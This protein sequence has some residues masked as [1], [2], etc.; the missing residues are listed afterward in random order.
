M[1]LNAVGLEFQLLKNFGVWERSDNSFAVI[2]EFVL[3]SVVY[4][5][6]ISK[7]AS[8]GSAHILLISLRNAIS[9]KRTVLEGAKFTR[10]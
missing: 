3:V 8:K 4:S 2:V 5:G 9:W 1:K 7:W 6:Y 10:V